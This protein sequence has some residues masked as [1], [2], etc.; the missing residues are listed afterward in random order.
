VKAIPSYRVQ[1]QD[2]ALDTFQAEIVD[3]PEDESVVAKAVAL[4]IAAPLYVTGLEVWQQDRCVFRLRSLA[5][6]EA[7]EPAAEPERRPRVLV[8][9]DNR[10]VLDIM[11][12]IC[13][14]LGYSVRSVDRGWSFMAACV[15]AMPDC[16]VLDLNL[17]DINGMSLLRWLLDIR[18][19]ARII[20]TSGTTDQAQFAKVSS[21]AQRDLSIAILRKPFELSDLVHLLREGGTVRR[22]TPIEGRLGE[23]DTARPVE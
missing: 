20:V 23:A 3:A 5:R 17:P 6:R 22:A 21:L 12:R 19:G 1:L 14:G 10:D 16:I 9:D 2:D 4:L 13:I 11:R 8:C 7:M 18:C 15:Q